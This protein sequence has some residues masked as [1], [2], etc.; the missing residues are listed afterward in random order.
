MKHLPLIALTL[1][2]APF[3]AYAQGEINAIQIKDN[4]HFLISP[5]GGN[6]L[7]STGEMTP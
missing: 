5:H 6:I 3:S 7:A 2:A 4:M 1:I